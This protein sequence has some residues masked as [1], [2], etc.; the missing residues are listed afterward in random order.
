M[1]SWSYALTGNLTQP[2]GLQDPSRLR[3]QSP[4]RNLLGP[5]G[6]FTCPP[7]QESETAVNRRGVPSVG[8]KDIT[9][10]SASMG[11]KI[12]SWGGRESYYFHK[13]EK[14]IHIVHKLIYSVSGGGDDSNKMSKTGPVVGG[15]RLRS[16]NE[17]M[18]DIALVY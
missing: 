16:N 11:A 1:G 12:G 7:D 2:R 15:G 18:E 17:K 9:L 3:K 13:Y 8:D 6:M 14:H 10:D 5:L 4:E